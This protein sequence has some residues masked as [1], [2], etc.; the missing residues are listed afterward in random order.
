MTAG[1]G[2][3]KICWRFMTH[4]CFLS[5]L[6]KG[7]NEE[8]RW[9]DMSSQK[10][11]MKL[12]DPGTKLFCCAKWWRSLVLLESPNHSLR[13]KSRKP[14]GSNAKS[15]QQDR[16]HEDCCALFVGNSMKFLMCSILTRRWY[17][18]ILQQTLGLE[19]L[20][21]GK[22]LVEHCRLCQCSLTTYGILAY[23]EERHDVM[24][25]AKPRLQVVPSQKHLLKLLK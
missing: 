11:R 4:D 9:S 7:F 13:N 19:L 8:N 21:P 6:R 23:L 16:K 3:W 18:P 12:S 14:C 17:I 20:A 10:I 5:F 25:A 1:I 22:F 24:A 2:K 15:Q